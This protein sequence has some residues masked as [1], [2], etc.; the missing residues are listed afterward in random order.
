MNRDSF[1]PN[2][3]KPSK[4]VMLWGIFLAY[5]WFHLSCASQMITFD[6]DPKSEIVLH[7]WDDLNGP[8]EVVGET[9]KS[10][11][12]ESLALKV[13]KFRNTESKT[14]YVSLLPET[15]GSIRASFKMLPKDAALKP[16][17]ALS[18]PPSE[19]PGQCPPCEKMTVMSPP[20]GN[21]PIIIYPQICPKESIKVVRE[22]C[23]KRTQV[24]RS[25]SQINELGKTL[26]KAMQAYH[27]QQR[28][29]VLRLSALLERQFPSLSA[30]HILKGLLALDLGK[31]ALAKQH[32]R[33]AK[34]L[35]PSDIDITRL[36]EGL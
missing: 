18:S 22:P 32:F 30:P 12:K 7:D 3:L 9:P 15:E 35:D 20:S 28:S 36:L 21:Q 2:T 19:N 10:F 4:R 34:E 1:Q 33:R 27:S 11:P 17:T 16:K 25:E 6:T 14:M 29:E 26:L 23:A 24:K 5:G 13:V 8:G 31:R